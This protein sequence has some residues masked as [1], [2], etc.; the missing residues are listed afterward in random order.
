MTYKEGDIVRVKDAA[1]INDEELNLRFLEEMKQ[2]CGGEYKVVGT[3]TWNN[4]NIYYLED[5]YRDYK[6]AKLLYAF[7]E[8]WLEPG[9]ISVQQIEE[10]ELIKI[11][12]L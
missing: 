1:E 9:V 11:F 2:F 5:A 3:D 7:A 8:E 4:I 6:R 10:N 12:K